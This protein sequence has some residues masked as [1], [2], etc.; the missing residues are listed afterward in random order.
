MQTVMAVGPD[1]RLAEK[2]RRGLED[3]MALVR[4]P[5]SVVLIAA[6]R[7]NDTPLRT[8]AISGRDSSHGIRW[9]P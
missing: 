2:A 3:A 4:R 9:N 5:G 1:Q 7:E 8:G 6:T